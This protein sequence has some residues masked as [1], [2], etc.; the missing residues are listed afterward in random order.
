MSDGSRDGEDPAQAELLREI[1]LL[2][3]EIL[4]TPVN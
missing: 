4:T 2:R 3:A 1:E